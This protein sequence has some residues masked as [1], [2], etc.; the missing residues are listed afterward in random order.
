M[1]MKKV[2]F[3]LAALM[4]SFGLFVFSSAEVGAVGDNTVRGRVYHDLDMNGNRNGGEPGLENWDV[5]LY[6]GSGTSTPIE[7]KQTAANGFAIFSLLDPGTY[8]VCQTLLPGWTNTEPGAP[9]FCGEHT[10]TAAETVTTEFGNFDPRGEVHGMKFED[11]DGDGVKDPEDEGLE[12]W[13][14]RLRNLGTGEILRTTTNADGE[15]WFMDVDPGDYRLTERQQTGWIPTVPVDPAKYEFT[16]GIQEIVTDL[17]FGNFE[18]GQI[19]GSKFNDLNGDGVWDDGE[20]GIQGWGITLLFDSNEIATTTTDADGNY[21]FMDVGPGLHQISEEQRQGWQQTQPDSTSGLRAANMTSGRVV[22]NK[23]FGNFEFGAIHGMKFQDT[24]GNGVKDGDEPALEGWKIKLKNRDTNEKFNMRTDADGKYWF[25]DLPPGRYRVTEKV[26]KGW[27]QTLPT[28]PNR[29]DVTLVSGDVLNDLDF[30]NFEKGELHGAKFEDTNGNGLWDQ[31]EDGL[32]DWTIE[33]YKDGQLFATTTTDSSGEYWFMD[34]GP[35]L[36]RLQEVLQQGWIQTAPDDPAHHQRRM[37]SGR[38][39]ENLDFGNFELVSIHGVKFEDV[40]KNGR[41]DRGDRP[42]EGWEIKLTGFDPDADQRFTLTTQTDAQGRYW[43]MGLRPGTYRLEEIQQRGWEQTFPADP[44]HYT[45]VVEE[46]GA[47]LEDYDFGNFLPGKIHGL[48]FEDVNGNGRR[49]IGESGLSGWTISLLVDDQVVETTT[50]NA[51][52]EY[53]FMGLDPNDYEVGEE[54][55]QGWVQTT[56]RNPF[57][58][59]ATIESSSVV[60]N[61]NFG[62]FERASVHGFKIEDENGDGALERGD[63][64]LEGWT[65]ELYRN[66]SLLKTT[67]TD[68]NGEYWFMDLP[69]GNYE[70]KEVLQQ[71]WIQTHPTSGSYTFRPRSGDELQG[72]NFGNF[73]LGALHGHKFEDVNGNGLWDD[74]ESALRGWKITLLKDGSEF[75]SMTTDRRGRYWFMDLGPGVYRVV[76]EDRNGWYQTVPRD[77]EHYQGRMLS[78]LVLEDLNFGNFELGMVHGHKFEDMLMDGNRDRNDPGIPG[79]VIRITGYDDLRDEPVDF[80]VETNSGGDFWIEDLGLGSFTISEI[81]PDGWTQTFPRFGDYDVTISRSGH[82]QEGLVFGNYHYGEIHGMKYEDNNENGRFDGGD[83]P[84]PGWG[85]TL[86]H[87]DTGRIERVVTNSE[88]EYWYM[89]LL[90]GRYLLTEEN[91]AGWQPVN[92]VS[93]RHSADIESSS[94]LILD[95]GNKEKDFFNRGRTRRVDEGEPV[96]V[97][98]VEEPQ[99][100]PIEEVEITEEPEIVVEEDESEVAE[101]TDEEEEGDD[102]SSQ[103]SDISDRR[104]RSSRR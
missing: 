15:Y 23:D 50:T 14:I 19:H 65:I 33:L 20:P 4:M 97:E 29:H 49:D 62:N 57:T 30:G 47:S 81:V 89:G 76:E 34:L 70:I 72:R 9:P 82:D 100:T 71:G 8:T 58:H 51:D 37:R 73:E 3:M 94:F 44:G 88:G 42:L 90:P 12:G 80:T 11:V 24:N 103:D 39:V 10:V 77:P 66:G 18:L 64:R 55:R 6:S 68:S 60:E 104:S 67:T 78:G 1:R 45:I 16:L 28:G 40:N 93:G 27:I 38:V 46:S 69:P 26:E 86:Q 36:Y 2:S 102:N 31:G 43:F 41:K 54:R 7:T 21:W 63:N 53:W 25:T 98:V 32:K 5:T 83:V 75:D 48:K 61:F 59:S 17:D 85:I 56:P 84:I 22:E 79:W 99:Q 74:G 52:G 92:P 87:L 35:G 13:T 101:E 96:E 95:F 91:R